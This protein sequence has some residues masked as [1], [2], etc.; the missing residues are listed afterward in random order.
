MDFYDVIEKR[1]SIRC[2]K[3]DAVP[4][5]SLARIEKA[6]QLAPTACNRQPFRLLI[7]KNA[8]LRANLCGA[9]IFDWLKQA[10]MIAVLVGDSQSA[11]TRFEGTSILDVDAGIVM[12]HFILAATAENLGTCWVC[13]FDRAKINEVLGIEAPWSAIALS[14]LGFG[15]SDAVKPRSVKAMNE[16]I[17]VIE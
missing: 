15:A 17:K 12:E 14:P 3:P 9:C 16:I 10:P 1:R 4:E 13:A 7:L 8:E 6:V 2:Y 5:D 11:W